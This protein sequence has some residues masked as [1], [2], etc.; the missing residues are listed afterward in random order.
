L[1]VFC[2]AILSLSKDFFIRF[3]RRYCDESAFRFNHKKS[4]QDERLVDALAN[5]NG[6]LKYK[7]LIG[8]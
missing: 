7:T 8:K 5:C 6:S 2:K 1:T 4:F 3:E